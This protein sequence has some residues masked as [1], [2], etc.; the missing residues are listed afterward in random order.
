MYICIDV[1]LDLCNAKMWLCSYF[2]LNTFSMKTHAIDFGC[3]CIIYLLDSVIYI[4]LTVLST[5]Y[6]VIYINPAVL[7]TLTLQCYLH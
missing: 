3:T 2:Q 5:P 1:A 4:N 6:S 7:S